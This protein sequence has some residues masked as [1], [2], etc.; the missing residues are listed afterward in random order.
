[1]NV[2]LFLKIL[3]YYPVAFVLAVSVLSIRYYFFTKNSWFRD[4][5]SKRRVTDFDAALWFSA[6]VAINSF[7]PKYV[8]EVIIKD[9]GN[10][11]IVFLSLMFLICLPLA[12]LAFFFLRKISPESDTQF[13]RVSSGSGI[14]KT[15]QVSALVLGLISLVL[16]VFKVYVPHIEELASD[17]LTFGSVTSLIFAL[18]LVLFGMVDWEQEKQKQK[19]G[20]R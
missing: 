1:M 20:G 5:L 10:L 3:A 13:L 7:I 2:E 8:E 11:S 19:D 6:V 16:Y 4:T 14:K 17:L 12:Q 18:F 9:Y 15:F